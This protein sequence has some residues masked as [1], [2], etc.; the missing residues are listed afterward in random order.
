MTLSRA[1]REIGERLRG[2]VDALRAVM[3]VVEALA[4]QKDRRPRSASRK[5]LSAHRS[6]RR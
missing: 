3:V 4:S 5:A 1:V 6:K 2:D